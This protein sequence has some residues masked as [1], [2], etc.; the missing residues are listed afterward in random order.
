MECDVNPSHKN[1]WHL[2]SLPGTGA[3]KNVADG[4]TGVFLMSS[5]YQSD[6]DPMWWKIKNGIKNWPTN[7][8]LF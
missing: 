7:L 5:R 2:G 3:F 6:V 4:T 8:D 1:I